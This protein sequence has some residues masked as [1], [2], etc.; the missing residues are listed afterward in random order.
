MTW[1]LPIGNLHVGEC[2]IAIGG[3][4]EVLTLDDKKQIE[5]LLI[6]DLPGP[7]LLFDHVEAR[8]LDVH[9]GLRRLYISIGQ[10][11]RSDKA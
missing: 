3:R 5:N 10:Y 2:Q 6:Q 9:L 11:S 1:P 7:D 4:N 8:L